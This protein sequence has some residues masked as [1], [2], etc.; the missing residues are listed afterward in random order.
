MLAGSGFMALAWFR[1]KRQ[2]AAPL[3]RAT[4]D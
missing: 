3:A 2:V 1:N 4:M